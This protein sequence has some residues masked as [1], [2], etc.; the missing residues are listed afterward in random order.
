MNKF[1][2]IYQGVL[3]DIMERGIA[4]VNKRTGHETR[5]LPG[6]H[7]SIDLEQDGFPL[8]TLRKIP[9]KMW[10]AEQI[11]FIAGSRKPED[12]LRQYTKIW[13]D[14]TNPGDVVTVAYG[15][16]WRKHFG[17]DQL[18]LLVDLLEHDPSSRQ[19]VV[20]TW[21]PA[22]DGLSLENKKKNVPCPYT[23]TVNI[24]GGRLHLHNIV[25]SNDFILG[26]PS[27]IAGFAL[28]Q[29]IL[30]QRLG[31][32]PG[33]YS[34]SISNAHI[35]DTHY[36]GAIELLGRVNDHPPISLKL[37]ER[38]F[39]RAENKDEALVEEIVEHIGSQYNP[40]EPIKGLKIVL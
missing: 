17:R 22:Q 10:V 11:W 27:D 16:R 8:L 4:E 2:T 14:F 28:L 25:R 18:Q 9:I 31:V 6:A 13:D 37:P 7:F 30:A 12:F 19:A 1:D 32:R 3:K 39:E 15:Y 38:T 34:H 40:M 24:I 20:V 29:S 35:Y 26:A 5:A 33:I 23:F 21:D 36:E